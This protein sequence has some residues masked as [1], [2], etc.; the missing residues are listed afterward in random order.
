MTGSRLTAEVLGCSVAALRKWRLLGNGPAYVKVG[1][2]I[3][4]AETDLRAYLDANRVSQQIG[5]WRDEYQ[6]RK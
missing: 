6:L 4:Y 1:R 3:R 2:L 5:R